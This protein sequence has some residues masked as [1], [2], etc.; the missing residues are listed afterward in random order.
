MRIRLSLPLVSFAI[1]L[2]GCIP[3]HYTLQPGVTGVVID[4]RNSAPVPNAVVAVTSR[5]S[6]RQTGKLLLATDADGKFHVVPKR[7]WGIY[8]VPMDIFGP[9]TEASISAP[10]Y[11]TRVFK[12]SASAMGP[13]AV[14]LGEVR[15]ARAE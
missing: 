9:W 12:L 14:A 8:I 1:G 5:D 11:E 6:S 10:G 7:R 15:L 4:D 13:K 2:C 3:Y